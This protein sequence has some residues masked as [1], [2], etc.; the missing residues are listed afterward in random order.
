MSTPLEVEEDAFEKR[1]G[2]V[3][4]D[5]IRFIAKFLGSNEAEH[6]MEMNTKTAVAGMHTHAMH[7][8][9]DG[10]KKS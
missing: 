8:G 3:Y 9:T 1:S 5:D 4:S 7:D 2:E 6:K 10:W